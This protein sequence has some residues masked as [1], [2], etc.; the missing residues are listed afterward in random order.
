MICMKRC[1]LLTAYLLFTNFLLSG[2]KLQKLEQQLQTAKTNRNK[3]YAF[4]ALADYYTS[5][6]GKDSIANLYGDKQIALA[7]Q[8]ENKELMALAYY[9]EG[10]RL[11]QA[12]PSEKRFGR[13][14]DCL[15]RT[16]QI[17]AQNNLP[18]YGAIA[19]IALSIPYYNGFEIDGDKAI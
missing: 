7:N 16:I 12:I 11:I 2:Q 13:A 10:E 9:L 19:Y 15:H 4:Y 6:L 14:K 1:L 8:T 5:T 3:I 17:E 18:F